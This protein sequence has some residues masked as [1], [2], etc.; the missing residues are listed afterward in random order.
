MTISQS[1]YGASAEVG[2][3]YT[4]PPREEQSTKATAASA[5]LAGLGGGA[6]LYGSGMARRAA[7]A[8]RSAAQRAISAENN[9]LVARRWNK[10]LIGQ[11]NKK[12]KPKRTPQHEAKIIESENQI[13]SA[14]AE[15]RAAINNAR[16]VRSRELRIGPKAKAF[17]RGGRIAAGIGL[18]G[19]AGSLYATERKR[20][21]FGYKRPTS[22]GAYNEGM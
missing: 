17:T 11:R 22:H 16:K 10:A 4:R 15:R 21:T 14:E 12:V 9:E 7:N 20:G 2:R 1:R 8:S 19:L 18:V 3:N 13:K 6:Y 5:G